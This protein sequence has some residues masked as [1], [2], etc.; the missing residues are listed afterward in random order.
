MEGHF[1]D[2]LAVIQLYE[3]PEE[4]RGLDPETDTR[5]RVQLGLTRRGL[6]LKL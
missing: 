2:S 1:N 4:R 3:S 5:L 6:Q